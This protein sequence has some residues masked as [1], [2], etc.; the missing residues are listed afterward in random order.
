MPTSIVAWL[1][2]AVF[3]VAAYFVYTHWVK[4]KLPGA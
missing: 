2:L 4:G 1:W 3:L